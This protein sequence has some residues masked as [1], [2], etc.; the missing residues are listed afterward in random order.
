MS[1][2]EVRLLPMS[3]AQLRVSRAKGESPKIIGYSAVFNSLSDGV[4][5]DA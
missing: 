2:I 1:D 3:H 4:Y 5:A